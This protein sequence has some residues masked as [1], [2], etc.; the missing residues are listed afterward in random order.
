ML[1]RNTCAQCKPQEL[2][3]WLQTKGFPTEA[4]NIGERQDTPFLQTAPL[5]KGGRNERK[6]RKE[7]IE[8]KQGFGD[9]GVS[10]FVAGAA[11]LPL[12]ANLYYFDPT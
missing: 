11:I 2:R 4:G 6:E 3:S 1:V 12:A 7:R 10:L 5:V 8:K 9:V